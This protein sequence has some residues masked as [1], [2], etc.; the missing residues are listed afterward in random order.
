MN[1]EE[2]K[3][4][5]V[6]VKER[7]PEERQQ[8]LCINKYGHI[9]YRNWQSFTDQNLEWFK[10]TF[11]HWQYLEELTTKKAALELAKD[12][13][14]EG[15]GTRLEVEMEHAKGEPTTLIYD[16]NIASFINEN[17]TAL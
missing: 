13:F 3:K 4:L 8:V 5:F 10:K 17:K 6:D 7:L 11:T 2:I 14:E 15:Y 12:A 9:Q 1:I 16:N